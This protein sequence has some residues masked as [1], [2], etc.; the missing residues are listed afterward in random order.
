MAEP[1]REEVEAFLDRFY[2]HDGWR[3]WQGVAPLI[4]ETGAAL[5]AAYA[6]RE[7]EQVD[8]RTAVVDYL[9]TH[10]ERNGRIARSLAETELVRSALYEAIEKTLGLA[11]RAIEA[12]EHRT[13]P[14]AEQNAPKRA[15]AGLSD[16]DGAE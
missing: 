3:H 7:R 15:I 14:A 9:L 4:V 8:E 12:G 1:T 2:G 11:A 16:E 10:C 5:A 6:V 13:Q